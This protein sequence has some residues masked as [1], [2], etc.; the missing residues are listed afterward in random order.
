LAGG[1]RLAV[2]L[3]NFMI[4]RNPIFAGVDI[5]WPNAGCSAW[6]G[7]GMRLEE[8]KGLGSAFR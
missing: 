2:S 3:K 5:A 4:S 1:T 7:F 6:K 8:L